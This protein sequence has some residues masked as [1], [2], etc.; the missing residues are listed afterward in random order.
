MS[1]H[2]GI[3]LFQHFLI[4]LSVVGAKIADMLDRYGSQQFYA[5]L[6]GKKPLLIGNVENQLSNWFKLN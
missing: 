1:G 6:T 4:F 5:A 3:K 2:E